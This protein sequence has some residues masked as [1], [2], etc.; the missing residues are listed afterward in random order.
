MQCIHAAIGPVQERNLHEYNTVYI[1]V[2]LFA[3][4]NLCRSILLA[5]M[6]GIVYSDFHIF[7]FRHACSHACFAIAQEAQPMRCCRCLVSCMAEIH[8]NHN[9]NLSL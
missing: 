3:E 1:A 4:C 8:E 2:V 9:L 6:H 7:N 5:H